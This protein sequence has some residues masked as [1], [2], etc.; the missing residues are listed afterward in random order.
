MA[1]P[2]LAPGSA[3]WV[4]DGA[5]GWAVRTLEAV[6]DNGGRLIFGD[7]PGEKDTFLVTQVHA[8]DPSHFAEG[9]DDIAEM[10]DLHLAPLFDCI[11]RRFLAD[12][13]YTNIGDILISVNPYEVSGASATR[14]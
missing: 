1:S 14:I 7:K 8:T 3:W 2:D 11:R 9:M 4:P 12:Q 6:A 13:I 10:G 5:D